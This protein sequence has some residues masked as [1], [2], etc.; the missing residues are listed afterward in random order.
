MITLL[1]WAYSDGQGIAVQEGYSKLPQELVF[2]V[3]S[4]V[5]SIK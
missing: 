2:K 4:K 5:N 1:N 3:L